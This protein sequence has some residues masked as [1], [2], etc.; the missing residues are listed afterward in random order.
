MNENC[1]E[2]FIALIAPIGINVEEVVEVLSEQANQ[3]GFNPN[4]I[5]LTDSLKRLGKVEESYDN[6]VE[7][8]KA[9]ITAGDKLCAD[10]GRG[11]AFILLGIADLLS[12]GDEN[13]RELANTK[14][15]NIFRQIKR[16]EEHD[17]L[18]RVYGRNILFLGCFAPKD[19]RKSFLVSKI[20]SS[21]RNSN[22]SRLESQALDI[23]AVD[24]EEAGQDFG[25]KIIDC[26]PKSDF[27]LDCTSRSSLEKSCERFFKIYFG[28]PFIAPNIDE[29]ASY[30]ANAAAY[31]SLDL[32]R[33][34]GAA[35]FSE[36][37]EVISMGCNEVPAPGGGT[38]WNHHDSDGRDYAMG[39]DSNQ[40]VREE[41]ARDILANL[42]QAGWLT[43]EI[44][45]TD[46][47]SLIKKA[48]QKSSKAKAI[49]AGP[50]SNSMISDIIEYG[51]M[52]H[53][54]MNALTDAARF[55]RST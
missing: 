47:N 11:D 44:S 22:I 26:Y 27:I 38:Y 19:N 55:R 7:R 54:E 14:R 43:K 50:L 51:R 29:Y 13:R 3:I 15:L 20:K 32:S 10:Y 45:E 37:G 16:L 52:V 6:E 46:S 9:Y 5:K 18:Q 21:A 36:N 8:Y 25:Q 34:V 28:H 42:N 30:I 33:Q 1:R 31:R 12:G 39:H 4:P 49:E 17:T 40:R 35:I 24:E 41:L 48:F 53:A 23:M 2:A